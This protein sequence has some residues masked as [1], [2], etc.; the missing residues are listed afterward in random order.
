MGFV[1]WNVG[2]T[3][4][5]ASLADCSYTRSYTACSHFEDAGVTCSGDTN[6]LL[7]DKAVLDIFAKYTVMLLKPYYVKSTSNI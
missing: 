3:G 4:E 2:C 6:Q 7:I 5:E 1:L